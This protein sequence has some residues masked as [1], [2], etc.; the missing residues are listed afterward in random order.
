MD[1]V[2]FDLLHPHLIKGGWRGVLV[3]PVPDMFAQL[4][5][6]YATHPELT[7]VNCAVTDYDGTLTLHRIDPEVVAAGLMREQALGMTSAYT[8]GE[9]FAS[10]TLKHI[11][12]LHVPC[13]TL[14]NLLA[15]QGVE[16]MH[17]MVIDTEGGDWMIA[18]Q[19][20]MKFYRPTL[21][22]LEYTGLSG[23]DMRACCAH[24]VGQG[25]KFALCEE[26][27]QNLLFY[28]GN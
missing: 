21:I 9:I 17:V 4:Q 14:P 12:D 15:Q 25:Y 2:R 13:V 28:L 8:K 18:R 1:G 20:D 26:D 11:H 5:Q 6:T 7:L 24:F 3:E 19:L 23:D 27:N 16:F 22:C 10:D